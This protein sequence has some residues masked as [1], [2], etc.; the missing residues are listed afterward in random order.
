[1]ARKTV[2]KTAARKTQKKRKAAKVAKR[3]KSKK[4][5]TKT[6]VAKRRVK[7]T[8]VAKKT[9][10]PKRSRTRSKTSRSIAPAAATPPP[11][12]PRKSRMSPASIQQFRELLLTKR[13]EL[14]GDVKTLRD[15]ALK[16]DSPGE[17]SHMPIHMAELG[18]DNF[19]QE[20]TLGL[21]ESEHALLKEIDDALLR[22]E[23]GTY[24]ICAATSQPIGAARLKAKP[25][26]KYCYE[27]VLAQE[28]GHHLGFSA[29]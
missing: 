24:G 8:P 6:K 10:K 26:A 17:A 20:L 11:P 4:K 29:P 7:R 14:I 21:I 9:A 1:M 15:E 18:S 13:T 2:K 12:K 22:I 25:W 23:H 3:A 19:E 28:K 27:Y 5:T 16:T